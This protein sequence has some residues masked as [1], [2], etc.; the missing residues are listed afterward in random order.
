MC[1]L[2]YTHDVFQWLEK[3]FLAY[4][5][6]WE[7]SVNEREGYTTAQKNRMIL[8]KETLLGLRITG[9]LYLQLCCYL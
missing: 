3:E 7:R 2:K 9:I 1:I 6:D 5:D 8:S 4:L